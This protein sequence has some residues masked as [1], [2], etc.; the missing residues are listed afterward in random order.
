MTSVVTSLTSYYILFS[1]YVGTQNRHIGDFSSGSLPAEGVAHPSR[2]FS[3]SLAAEDVASQS[4]VT[5]D[6]Q[7]VCLSVEPQIVVIVRQLWF[8]RYGVPYLTRGRVC[9][10]S[11]CTFSTCTIHGRIN[12]ISIYNIYKA[13]L[14]PG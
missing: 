11:I 5:A 2:C 9:H 10:L 6:G 3:Q 8:C 14:S 7:S 12:C 4:H 1:T 13:S